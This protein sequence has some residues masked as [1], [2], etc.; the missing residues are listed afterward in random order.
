MCYSAQIR[1]DYAKFVRTYGAIIDIAEFV[2]LYWNRGQ[3]AK[4]KIPKAMDAA[5]ADPQTEDERRI[6]ALIARYD[7]EQASLL[8]QE[9][10][11]QR[12]R[13]G[14]AERALQ[15]R[16]TKAATESRR[17]ATAKVEWALGKLSDLRRTFL[18]DED[19]RIFPGWYAPVI[20][21]EA[22]RRVVK[23][24]RYQCR[25]PG[26]QAAWDRQFPGCYNA[27]RDNLEG[28]WKGQF[29][30]SH[31]IVV[32][33]AFFENV[34]RHR[35]EGRAL[36]EGEKEENVIL[37][38]RPR[39]VQDMLV[40]CLWSTWRDPSG[41]E[42]ELLSFAAI[43]DDPAP[44]IAAAGHDRCVIPIRHEHMDAWLDPATSKDLK[45]MYAILDDR[46]RPYYEHRLAA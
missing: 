17:I 14:D 11:K 28:F 37:E 33:N 22:G 23:P 27:R 12:K 25:L 26:K 32:L 46:E 41:K 38:F 15:A 16:T 9:V 31:G 6:A 2:R 8:E 35:V 24:M 7:Q 34:S 45:R 19:A 36:G 1:H 18:T 21:M 4:L 42:P 13:L 43:T 20:V 39:P 10:F 3:G 5:F 44:E 30:V 40:A 29:G